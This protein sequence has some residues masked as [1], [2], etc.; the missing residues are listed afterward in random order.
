MPPSFVSWL[1]PGAW[2]T[3]DVKSRPFGIFSIASSRR[4]VA[5]AL[6]LTSMSGDSPTTWTVSAMPPG[7]SV[8]GM[9]STWPRRRSM[10]ETF[11][12]AKPDRAAVTS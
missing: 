6:C 3:S 7:A 10:F 9:L 2:V 11:A 12:V 4:F 5:R 1:A 8:I